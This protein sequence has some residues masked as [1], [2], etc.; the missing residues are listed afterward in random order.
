MILF[1]ACAIVPSLSSYMLMGVFVGRNP[2]EISL[3][4]PRMK[5]ASRQASA[6]APSSALFE[7]RAIKPC[8]LD[9][10]DTR[11]LPIK[12][13]KAPVDFLSSKLSAQLA[14]GHPVIVLLSPS[15]WRPKLRVPLT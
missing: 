1:C 10:H 2:G 9:D 13:K 8:F 12:N 6:S 15:Y 7:E 14:S 3:T 4:S 11:Q 5:T